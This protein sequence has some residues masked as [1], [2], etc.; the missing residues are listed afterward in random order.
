MSRYPNIAVLICAGL[1]LGAA[2]VCG[3]DVIESEDSGTVNWSRRKIQAA[4]IGAPPDEAYGKPQARLLALR[5]AKIDALRNLLE[6]VKGVHIDSTTRVKDF[7]VQK[8]VV[9]TRVEGLVRGAR[10]VHVEYMPDG[11]VEVVM[12]IDLHGEFAKLTLPG[13]IERVESIRTP[14]PESPPADAFTG[15]VVDA[16]GLKVRPAMAP[17]IMDEKGAEVF[18]SAF[19]SREYAVQ[20]GVAGYAGDLSAAQTHPRVANRPITVKALR[21]EGPGRCDLVIRNEDAA[22]L[23]NASEHI[24]FLKKCR[25]MLVVD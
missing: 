8:D 15:L 1:L 12:E 18:G 5:A 16:R 10:Q 7:E 4:G 24:G 23:R 19:V 6:T 21:T 11:T 20:K 25:V 2:G 9:M 14:P 3:Q 13:D 22:K 17:K